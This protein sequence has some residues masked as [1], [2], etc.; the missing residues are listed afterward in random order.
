MGRW[1]GRRCQASCPC[2][3]S[4]IL[5][6][7]ETRQI[8]RHRMERE[9]LGWGV[10]VVGCCC[11]CL[12]PSSYTYAKRDRCVD[13]GCRTRD[14]AGVLAWSGGGGVGSATP[15]VVVGFRV[16]ALSFR[17]SA[18]GLGLWGLGFRFQ[19]LGCRVGFG[20]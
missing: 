13:I 11:C 1:Q 16:W 20:V 17:L 5:Y 8:Y 3:R 7:R 4:F 6:I 15:L 2:L 19:G 18:M 14:V 10:A 9:R 12:N